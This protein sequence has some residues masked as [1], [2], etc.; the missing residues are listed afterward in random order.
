[1]LKEKRNQYFGK[2]KKG[3]IKYWQYKGNVCE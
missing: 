1:M 3:S 2:E